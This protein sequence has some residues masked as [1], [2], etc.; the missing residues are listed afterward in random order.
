MG[1]YDIRQLLRVYFFSN[2]TR[3]TLFFGVVELMSK[4]ALGCPVKPQKPEAV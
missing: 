4:M 3:S 2:Q 1:Q